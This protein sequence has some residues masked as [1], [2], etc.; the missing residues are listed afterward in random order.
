MSTKAEVVKV[1][2][3][4]QDVEKAERLWFYDII[5]D[6]DLGKIR[7]A[8]NKNKPI[9]L[10]SILNKV[11]CFKPVRVVQRQS[12]GMQLDDFDIDNIDMYSRNFEF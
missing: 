3:T 1:V 5:D 12:T 2:P 8:F 4:K 7:S 6:W 11:D 10:A 9:D